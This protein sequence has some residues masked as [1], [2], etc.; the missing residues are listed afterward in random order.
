M[1]NIN[2]EATFSSISKLKFDQA[3][4][5]SLLNAPYKYTLFHISI[6][7]ISLRLKLILKISIF[8]DYI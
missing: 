5:P 6:N 2:T 4:P 8:K 7:P 1:F 3:A